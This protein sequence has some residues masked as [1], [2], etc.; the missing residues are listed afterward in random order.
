MSKLRHK[1]IDL[2]II[3]YE[4]E[5]Y[6]F[7][8]NLYNSE[9]SLHI[10]TVIHMGWFVYSALKRVIELIF[11]IFVTQNCFVIPKNHL[12]DDHLTK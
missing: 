12:I 7:N 3:I 4:Y 5:I 6:Y 11:T 1:L 2:L 9:N 10:L 8:I